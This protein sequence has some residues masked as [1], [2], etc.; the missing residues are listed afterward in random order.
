MLQIIFYNLITKQYYLENR[1][2]ESDDS[3]QWDSISD[4][5]VSEHRSAFLLEVLPCRITLLEEFYLLGCIIPV[6]FHG[7]SQVDAVGENTSQKMLEQLHVVLW[8]G[9]P[10]IGHHCLN[11]TEGE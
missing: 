8:L 1:V 7:G 9:G 2:S 4:S 5:I 3:N 11:T 10:V 6:P